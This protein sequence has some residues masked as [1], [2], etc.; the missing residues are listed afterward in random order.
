MMWAD[1]TMGSILV[2]IPSVEVL[3]SSEW[4]EL[5]ATTV[6]DFGVA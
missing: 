2:A 6:P 3:G 5:V 4:P 1:V